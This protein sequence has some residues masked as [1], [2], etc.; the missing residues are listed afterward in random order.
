MLSN[1]GQ[2]S[3][4]NTKSYSF[5]HWLKRGWGWELGVEL[6]FKK[7]ILQILYFSEGYL[8]I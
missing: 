6:M 1:L 3:S 4:I 8:A 5:E 2:F 7:P